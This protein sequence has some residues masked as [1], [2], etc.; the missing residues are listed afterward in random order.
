[1]PSVKDD[2]KT[3]AMSERKGER[4]KEKVKGERK[5]CD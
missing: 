1:M 3:S 2:A 5:R 4:M